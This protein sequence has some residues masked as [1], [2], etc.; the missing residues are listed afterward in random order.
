MFD[1]LRFRMVKMSK[2]KNFESIAFYK[3]NMLYVFPFNI[4]RSGLV[5]IMMMMISLILSSIAGAS[6]CKEK[7]HNFLKDLYVTQPYSWNLC[8]FN[9]R[10]LS[11]A[12]VALY[13]ECEAKVILRNHINNVCSFVQI[14][15]IYWCLT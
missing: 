14:W 3:I 7:E 9:T 2:M 4:L 6:W 10:R 15:C 1:A 11:L 13:V 8:I 5:F 12:C